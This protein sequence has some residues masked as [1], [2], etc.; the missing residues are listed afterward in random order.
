MKKEYKTTVRARVAKHVVIALFVSIVIVSAVNMI[1]MSRRAS[2]GQQRE[3][4]MTTELCALKVDTWTNELRGITVDLADTF[5]AMGA[6]EEKPVKAILNQIAATHPDLIFL[7]VATEEGNMYMARG[8]NYATGV[9]PRQRGWY[10][11]AKDARKTIVTDP[12]ISATRPDLMLATAAT[13]IYVDG[14]L[15]GIVGVDA[16]VSTINEYINSMDF[17][18]GSYGFLL[19]KRFIALQR[20]CQSFRKS[21]KLS[22]RKAKQLVL[23]TKMKTLFTQ[24]QNFPFVTGR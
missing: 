4:T 14:E 19:F 7:Y 12:Y 15:I 24:F 3:L 1:Y 5:R 10:Q 17:D 11:M 2:K 23:I 16:D 22:L 9:D 20:L 18:N 6:L 13:P 8:V 21:L